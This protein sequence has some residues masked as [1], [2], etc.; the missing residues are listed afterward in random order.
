[1]LEDVAREKVGIGFLDIEN[2]KHLEDAELN[3]IYT[4]TEAGN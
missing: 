4:N 2:K 3:E 1:M